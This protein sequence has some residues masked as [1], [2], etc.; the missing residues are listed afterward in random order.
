MIRA[1]KQGQHELLKQLEAGQLGAQKLKTPGCAEHPG[2][3]N[4]QLVQ[5]LM[6]PALAVAMPVDVQ[7]RDDGRQQHRALDVRPLDEVEPDVDAT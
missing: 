5:S 6:L 7:H 3:G 4:S 2:V 1:A